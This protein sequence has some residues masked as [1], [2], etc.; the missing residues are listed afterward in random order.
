MSIS[1]F[2]AAH[3][4]VL[5]QNLKPLCVMPI[6]DITAQQLCHKMVA[7]LAGGGGQY[8][9]AATDLLNVTAAGAVPAG[10]G[11]GEYAH[12]LLCSAIGYSLQV[13]KVAFLPFC[14]V[15]PGAVIEIYHAVCSPALMAA[16]ASPDLVLMEKSALE[17]ETDLLH[18]LLGAVLTLTAA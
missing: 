11:S 6:E 3:C 13:R 7:V 4:E 12:E 1:P 2:S 18:P 17:E 9:L 16:L 15:F 14:P 10:M 5:D 8:L